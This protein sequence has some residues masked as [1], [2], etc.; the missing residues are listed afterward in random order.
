MADKE[1]SHFPSGASGFVAGAI[2]NGSELT[3]LDKQQRLAR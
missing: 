3:P 1:R 2:R